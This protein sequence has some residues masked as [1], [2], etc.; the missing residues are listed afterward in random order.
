MD[1]RA[2]GGD[3]SKAMSKKTSISEEDGKARQSATGDGFGR[4]CRQ[5]GEK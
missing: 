4:V 3:I 2:V 1:S 5:N